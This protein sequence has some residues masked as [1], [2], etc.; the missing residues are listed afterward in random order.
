MAVKVL[1]RVDDISDKFD[2][3]DLS[4]W[5]IKKFPEIPVCI[6]A[7]ATHFSYMWQKAGWK[8]IKDMINKYKWEIG[9]HS[10]THRY[11]SKLPTNE[12][13]NDIEKNLEDIEKGLKSVGFN[14]KITSF[15]YPY[16]DLNEKV[17]E[18][19]KSNGILFGLTY[20]NKKEYQSLLNIPKDNLYEIGISCNAQNSV[21]D[22]NNK[23]EYVYKNGDTYILCLHTSHWFKGRNRKNIL[24]IIKSKSIKCFYISLKRFFRQLKRKSKIYMWDQLEQH[25]NY[26][27]SFPD[28]DFITFKHL[29]NE[30]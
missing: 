17:K 4:K 18:L 12:L 25:L 2:V 24:R 22:W 21:A 10:R 16:G 14:Y 27:K 13:K 8:K 5:F 1:I 20:T 9:G 3:Y 28:I 29:I 11:L 7:N 23:F 15:A 19:L 6:Y 30:K 26:I